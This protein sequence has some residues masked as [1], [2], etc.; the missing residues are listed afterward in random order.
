[1]DTNSLSPE[2]SHGASYP[3]TPI[4]T[5]TAP[6]EPVAAFVPSAAHIRRRAKGHVPRPINAFM[7]FRS[8]LCATGELGSDNRTVSV[9][10]GERWKAMPPA[11]RAPFMR[12]AEIEKE[13]HRR[14]YPDYKYAPAAVR[15]AR[16]ALKAG[17]GSTRS[18]SRS[19]ARTGFSAGA[20]ELPEAGQSSRCDTA[21]RGASKSPASPVATFFY[22]TLQ[23]PSRSPTPI[24]AASPTDSISPAYT[25]TPVY[26]QHPAAQAC[27][28]ELITD[29]GEFVPT[30]HIPDLHLG[31]SW[32]AKVRLFP[33]SR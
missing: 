24:A 8:W 26:L 14:M 17:A 31:D 27:T 4:F 33:Y 5:P 3:P 9:V 11:A 21:S 13:K 16:P 23:Y 20:A 18:G 12:G 22:D 32:G 30:E 25:S 28:P 6:T 19:R 7:L 1:M 10:A 2:P 29:E 15:K